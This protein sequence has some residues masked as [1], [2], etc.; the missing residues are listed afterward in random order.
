M[1]EKTA[2]EQELG[3]IEQRKVIK[4]SVNKQLPCGKV[5][6]I[7]KAADV[8][9]H[10]LISAQP[11]LILIFP[12]GGYEF[13]SYRESLN[14]ALAF[15]KRGIDAAVLHY[16]TENGKTILASG[17]GL[18][19]KPLQEAA[20]AMIA[21]RTDEDLGFTKHKI[22]VSG[23][24]AGAHLA[25][26]VCN[27]YKHEALKELTYEAQKVRP[28]GAVLGYGVFE[29]QT[30]GHTSD[31]VFENLS[32]S[33]DPTKWEHFTLTDKVSS[34]TPPSFIWHTADDAVVPVENSLHY[35]QA[36]WQHGGIA[37]LTI[38][39]KGIHGLATATPDVEPDNSFK[40]ADPH[41]APWVDQ[42]VDFIKTYVS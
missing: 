32:G 33:T 42:A 21:L 3:Y 11:Y 8:A 9:P 22:V 34:D 7:I 30:K 25:A 20:E 10:D 17:K 29:I 41:V 1:D 5:L 28:D 18:L 31:L 2:K 40:Y 24:S 15:A 36:M 35:A 37:E 16:T 38:F 26:S 19:Y 4:V 14:V 12:G 6:E 39:P 23:Y 13:T 27:L